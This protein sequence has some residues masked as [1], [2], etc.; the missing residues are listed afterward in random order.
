MPH[1][2]F[3]LVHVFSSRRQSPLSEVQ[4]LADKRPPLRKR[5]RNRVLSASCS[6]IAPRQH[7]HH[8][9]S[10][11]IS[12]LHNTAGDNKT[13]QPNPAPVFLPPR[14]HSVPP[15]PRHCGE[16]RVYD[17]KT[18]STHEMSTHAPPPPPH[19]LHARRIAALGGASLFPRF[20]WRIACPIAPRRIKGFR[21]QG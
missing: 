7:H 12:P 20:R 14:Q 17:L 2:K 8:N 9:H 21:G 3:Y 18:T 19:G 4:G 5:R 10:R 15:P 13:R 1:T 6:R 11:V 16:S